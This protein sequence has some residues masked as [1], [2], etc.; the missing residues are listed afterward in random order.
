MMSNAMTESGQVI[1]IR[2]AINATDAI[3]VVAS[4]TSDIEA[5][6]ETEMIY[7]YYCFDVRCTVPTMTGRKAISMICLVDAVNGLGA[8]ADSFELK[9]ETVSGQSLLDAAI[10]SDDAIGIAQRTVTH[11]LG[12]RLRTINSFDVDVRPRGLVHK[13]FWIVR[14][15][16][17]RIMVDSTNGSLH[18]LKLRAA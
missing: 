18:P 12:R 17:A 2:G 16:G 9:K 10:D 13:R 8:T 4:L 1:V 11:R 7:P 5:N 3:C 15:T 14:T 6:L